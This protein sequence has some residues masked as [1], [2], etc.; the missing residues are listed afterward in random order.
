MRNSVLA[1]LWFALAAV[2]LVGCGDSKD[3]AGTATQTEN[4]VAYGTVYHSDGTPARGAAVRIAPIVEID[5]P[6]TIP[7]IRETV[8]DTLGKFAFDEVVADTFQLA[9]VDRESGEISYLPEAIVSDDSMEVHLGKATVVTG[10]LTYNDSTQASIAVGSHF[11][12]YVEN[13]PFF[14]SVFA[15]GDFT[16]LVPEGSDMIGFCPWDPAVLEKLKQSGMADS[17]IFGQWEIP[18]S[19]AKGDTL[20]TGTLAWGGVSG[21]VS[22]SSGS[23]SSVSGGDSSSS[24]VGDSSSSAGSSSESKADSPSGWISGKVFCANSVPCDSVE[25]MVITDLFGFGFVSGEVREF[26]AQART[27]SDGWWY[28]PAPAEV[29]YD[30][31][32]VEFRRL[33]GGTVALSGLSRYVKGSEITDLNDTLDL[34]V[35]GMDSP[36]WVKTEVRLV[37]NQE[38]QNQTGYC[39]MNSVVLGIEG[40]S[41]FVR[42]M[43]CNSYS[44]IYLPSGSQRLLM[45]SGDPLVVSSLQESGVPQS[46]Y[47]TFND[48]VLTAGAGM[49]QLMLTYTPPTVK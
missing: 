7:E 33:S 42:T 11:V 19:A 31:F 23:T 27:D 36:S 38:D 15:P 28:L 25:V 9:V 20:K 37:I 22:S 14:E 47:V 34:G 24:R 49:D 2:V 41:H 1:L 35:T 3:V 30:S 12:V 5:G 21:G 6:R 29:P 39:F 16:L 32:R 26:E 13:T 48:L 4:T 46:S 18:A 10:T 17:A 40:T 8:T 44:L 45:Y 43:T